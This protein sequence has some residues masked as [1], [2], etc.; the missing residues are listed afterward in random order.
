MNFKKAHDEKESDPY[1]AG[2]SDHFC[3]FVPHF[4]P[5]YRSTWRT[6]NHP[7]AEGGMEGRL[8]EASEN[9]ELRTRNGARA[10]S[11]EEQARTSGAQKAGWSYTGRTA[12][13]RQRVHWQGK[14]IRL[15][16][17]VLDLRDALGRAEAAPGTEEKAVTT[18]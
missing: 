3:S 5:D 18:D 15:L 16:E 17:R 11:A 6:L 2:P 12:K 8:E 10:D 1:I 9:R 14:A 4:S 13:V 7:T